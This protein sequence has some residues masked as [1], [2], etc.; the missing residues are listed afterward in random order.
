MWP[1]GNVECAQVFAEAGFASAGRPDDDADLPRPRIK[2]QVGVN[3]NVRAAVHVKERFNPLRAVGV[4]VGTAVM[5]ADPHTHTTLTLRP[6]AVS[7]LYS[8]C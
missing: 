1:G 2:R 7:C 4:E 3:I 8:A 6:S 5:D